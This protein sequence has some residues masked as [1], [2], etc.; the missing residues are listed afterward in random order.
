MNITQAQKLGNRLSRQLS[1]ILGVQPQRVSFSWD[2]ATAI[3]QSSAQTQSVGLNRQYIQNASRREVAGVIAHELGHVYDPRANNPGSAKRTEAFGDAARLALTG[4]TKDWQAS[5]E[6]RAIAQKKGWDMGVEG[7]SLPGLG[8]H[9][10]RMR[11]TFANVLSKNKVDYTNKGGAQALPSLS[12]AS[13]A[14]YYGQL[15]GLYAG[16]QSQITALRN[17]RVGLRADFHEAVTGA[18]GEKLAGL[19]AVE[20]QSIERGVLGSSADLQERSDVRGTAEAQIRA[21]ERARLEGVAANR[22]SQQQA[23]LDYYMGA[24]GLEA[25]KLAE[26]Q[27]LLAQQLQQNSIISGQESQMDVLKAIYESLSGGGGGRGPGGGG[28]PVPPST[29]LP[30]PRQYLPNRMLNAQVRYGLRPGG[31]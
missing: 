23:G 18:R 6:A 11:N 13:T 21:A 22:L 9:G 20:N 27:Q 14:N 7:P 28:G 24:Q 19:A 5:P 4:Q 31:A 15:A 26:Q 12:P 17:Q 16:Y 10:G 1:G 8:K 25:Q 29:G 3:A 2:P 30:I